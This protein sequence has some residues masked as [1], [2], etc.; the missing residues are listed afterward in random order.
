MNEVGHPAEEGPVEIMGV[1]GVTTPA[2]RDRRQA[3]R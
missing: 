1:P 3:A 2:G